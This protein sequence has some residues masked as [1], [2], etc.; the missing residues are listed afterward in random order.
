MIIT[1]SLLPCSQN[2]FHRCWWPLHPVPGGESTAYKH[3][4]T[5]VP[6][7]SRPWCPQS[8]FSHANWHT[9]ERTEEENLGDARHLFTL[10]LTW[11]LSC[12]SRLT[13]PGHS[14][15]GLGFVSHVMVCTCCASW[16]GYSGSRDNLRE[17]R[18]QRVSLF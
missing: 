9:G 7:L 12:P 1:Y 6:V 5:S 13:G 10:L 14:H 18:H 3:V 17:L 2:L 8:H 15:R 16:A 4:C 11:A